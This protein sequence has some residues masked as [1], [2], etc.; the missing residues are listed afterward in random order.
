MLLNY[1]MSRRGKAD[2]IKDILELCRNPV[3]K[4]AIVYQCNLNFKIV[5]RYFNICFTN[6]WLQKI[7]NKYQT[8]SLGIDAIDMLIPVV[9]NLQ[10]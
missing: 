4:T 7:D 6:G 2:I 5:K 8:T 10:F 9:N 1:N 3:N